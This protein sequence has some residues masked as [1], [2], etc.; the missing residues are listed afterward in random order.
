MVFPAQ[1]MIKIP[2][3]FLR[4]INQ[5]GAKDVKGFADINNFIQSLE[6]PKTVMMLVPAGKIV[7]DVIAELLPLLD[8]GDIIIDGGNS[9][10]TDTERRSA[11]FGENGLSFFWNG[12][13][14]R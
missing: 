5:A 10:F 9:H 4:S 3:K 1:G 11:D 6:R 14:R 12:Y 8:K 13:F 7:D 2:T